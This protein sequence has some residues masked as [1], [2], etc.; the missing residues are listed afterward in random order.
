MLRN[1]S[2]VLLKAKNGAGEL[3][4][5]LPG[6]VGIH[7]QKSKCR[8]NT[9]AEKNTSLLLYPTGKKENKTKPPS[10]ERNLGARL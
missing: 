4:D 2:E 8:A 1:P 10:E 6:I 3:R 5:P 9:G 7:F